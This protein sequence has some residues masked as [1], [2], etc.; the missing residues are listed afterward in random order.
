[1]KKLFILQSVVYFFLIIFLF[2]LAFLFLIP[3]AVGDLGGDTGIGPMSQECFGI[4][5][6]QSRLVGIF[7]SGSW[8][9]IIL[10]THFVYSVPKS[11]VT[12]AGTNPV[13][14]IGI[15]IWHGE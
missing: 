7:H 3:P 6:S 5:I 12:P 2:I 10:H 14:C 11:P 8:E 13:Y 1:M 15:D 4:R 9:K